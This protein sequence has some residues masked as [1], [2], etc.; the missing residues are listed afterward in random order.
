MLNLTRGQFPIRYCI[1]SY[2]TILYYTILLYYINNF[3]GAP[4]PPCEHLFF[5]GQLLLKH[6]GDHF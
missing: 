1:I 5:V 6:P 4:P 3:L 2:Y